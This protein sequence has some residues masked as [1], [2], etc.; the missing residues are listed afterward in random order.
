MA[1]RGGMTGTSIASP[2]QINV[3]FGSNYMTSSSGSAASGWFGPSVPPNPLG[4]SEVSGRQWDF[5]SGYN[6]STTERPYAPIG[7]RELRQFADGYDLLRLV[8]ETRKDQVSRMT[9]SIKARAGRQPN[10]AAADMIDKI[11]R[12]FWRP[13]G[14]HA[15]DTWLRMLLEDLFVTDA[16]ALYVQRDRGGNLHALLPMDGATIKPVI[17]DWGRTPRPVTQNGQTIYPVAYQQILKGYPA[18]NY[19]V[20]DIIYRPRNVR[21][22]RVY[23]YSPV[24]QVIATIKIGLLRQSFLMDYYTEGNI[25]DSLIGVPD[26]WTPDQVAS[27]QRYWDAYFDGPEGRRRRAKFVPGGVAKTFIQTKEPDLK[28]PLDEWLARVICLAFSMSPQ[29]LVSN[30]NRATA[31]TQKDMAEEEGLFP[32]LAW[33][34]SIIDEIIQN[35]FSSPDLEFVWGQDTQIDPT[36]QAS[37]LTDYTGKGIMK[38][39]EARERLGLDPLEDPAANMAMVLT[40]NGY[41]PLDANV[42]AAK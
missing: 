24:E 4:P 39:N 22:N 17:D 26:N 32:I 1:E 35:E 7:F 28:S 5:P 13:D 31:E 3:R 20:R 41:V 33:T 34:K 6:L 8:I 2:Y 42:S 11:T 23:G 38:I 36:V 27:Y 37:I 40:A 29:S 25:P 19:S 15:W 30:L 16:S 14:Q 9:W 21:T 12:F 10:S 18:I